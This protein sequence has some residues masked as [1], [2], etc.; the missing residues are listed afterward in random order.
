VSGRRGD[1]LLWG[2]RVGEVAAGDGRRDPP[3]PPPPGSSAK[4]PLPQRGPKRRRCEFSGGRGPFIFGR[5]FAHGDINTKH[6]L[7]EV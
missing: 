7:C 6:P 3:R 4:S 1:A 5:E 2:P